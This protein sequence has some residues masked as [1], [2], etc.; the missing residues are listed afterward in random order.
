L[1][2]GQLHLQHRLLAARALAEDVEDEGDAVERRH[3]PQGLEVA[4]LDGGERGVDEHSPH[5][6]VQRAEVLRDVRGGALPKVRGSV[7]R[8]LS[9]GALYQDMWRLAGSFAGTMCKSYGL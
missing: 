8:A 2:L 3:E 4:L 9:K 5:L 1:E 7:D 6:G